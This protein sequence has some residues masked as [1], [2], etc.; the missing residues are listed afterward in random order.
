VALKIYYSTGYGASTG[1]ELVST[2][3]TFNSGVAF[4][5]GGEFVV[6]LRNNGASTLEAVASITLTVRPIGSTASLLVGSVIQG[7]RGIQGVKGDKGLKGDPGVGG[8]GSPGLVWSGVFNAAN[9]Y[10]PPQAVSYTSGGVTQSYICKLNNPGPGSQPPTN[11]TYWDLI[12]G[13][14]AVTGAAFRWMSTWSNGTTYVS[15]TDYVDVVSYTSGSVT[16]AYVCKVASSLNQIPPSTPAS[17]DVFASPGGETPVYAYTVLSGAGGG[18]PTEPYICY[19]GTYVA[20]TSNND[21]LA[22][23]APSTRNNGLDFEE[24]TVTNSVTTPGGVAMLSYKLRSSFKGNVYVRLP[25][26]S[27]GATV[28]WNTSNTHCFA[29]LES[30]GTN[31]SVSYGTDAV[32]VISHGTNYPTTTTLYEI[33]VATSEPRNVLVSFIGMSS[34]P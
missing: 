27:N 32:K 14:T 13:A 28:N 20:G 15:D 6:A 33:D 29:V 30:T 3:S 11:T 24:H 21:Y 1:V 17:W 5:N 25:N 16:S 4:Y 34:V 10:A 12:A 8:A 18:A 19:G 22:V 7:Q 26:T 2:T 9:S 31:P 23:S